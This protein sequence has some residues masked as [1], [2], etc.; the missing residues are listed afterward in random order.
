MEDV[1]LKTE[2]DRKTERE[3]V[4]PGKQKGNAT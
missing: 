3:D 2:L 4:E 1:A